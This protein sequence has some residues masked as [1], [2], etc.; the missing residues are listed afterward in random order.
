MAQARNEEMEER[1]EQ[2]LAGEM[3]LGPEMEARL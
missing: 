2:T 3:G 1:K